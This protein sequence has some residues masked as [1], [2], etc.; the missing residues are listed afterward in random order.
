MRCFLIIHGIPTGLLFLFIILDIVR[1]L[2][3]WSF[4]H[5]LNCVVTMEEMWLL[6][7]GIV[8][9]LTTITYLAL[10]HA[11]RDVLFRRLRLRGRRASTANTPPRSLSPG[12]KGQLSVPSPT[13]YI[14]SFPGSR[15]EALAKVMQMI[16]QASGGNLVSIETEKSMTS[17]MMM[18]Y[19]ANYMEA[20]ESK[21]SPTGFSVAEIKALGDFPNYAELS[22]VP[23]PKSYTDFDID[24]ALPRPYR[25]FRWSYHQTMCRFNAEVA[26]CVAD[27]Y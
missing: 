25:P 27:L 1:A 20:D 12:K 5:R 24:K 6:V 23:L 3:F 21:Y 22:G 4:L 15:R 17:D 7:L 13:E 16:P 2:I 19:E 18:P 11:Q 10:S 9:C 26:R 14:E 8:F